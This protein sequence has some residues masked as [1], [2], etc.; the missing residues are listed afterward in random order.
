MLESYKSKKVALIVF[1]M[2]LFSIRVAIVAV[3][4]KA[5]G[6]LLDN[7]IAP[8]LVLISIGYSINAVFR[9]GN[10]FRMINA[11]EKMNPEVARIN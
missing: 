6:M 4:W 11:F 5:S 10:V 8:M 3:L 1:A 7:P 9:F 2:L